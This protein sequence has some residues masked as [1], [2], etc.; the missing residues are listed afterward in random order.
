[1]FVTQ[2]CNLAI[3]WIGNLKL[4]CLEG[5][6]KKSYCLPTSTTSLS[7]PEI[8]AHVFLQEIMWMILNILR[9][10]KKYI[11]RW[12]QIFCTLLSL[13]FHIPYKMF[14]MICYGSS[15][16]STKDKVNSVKVH[17]CSII[18]DASSII[19][20]TKCEEKGIK[21][22]YKFDWFWHHVQLLFTE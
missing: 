13:T 7:I 2:K 14:K 19:Y 12:K 4:Q 11:H 1:M 5:Y 17:F 3:P 18:I 15:S 6:H 20:N 21:P 22:L 10:D 8:N 9:D 16:I